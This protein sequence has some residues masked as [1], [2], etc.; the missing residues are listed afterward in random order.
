MKC[1]KCFNDYNKSNRIAKLITPCGH[2]F[3]EDCLKKLIKC[4]NCNKVIKEKITNF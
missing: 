1:K 2:T 4:P 3:C